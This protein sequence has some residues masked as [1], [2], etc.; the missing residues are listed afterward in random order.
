MTTKLV[1]KHLLKGTR[2][3]ELLDEQINVRM[4]TP[5]GQEEK[6]TVMLAVLNE[7]PVISRSEL[8]FTSRVNSE[9]LLSMFLAKPNQDEFN[10]FVNE[11]KERIKDEFRAFA[12]LK[13]SMPAGM[14]MNVEDEPPEFGSDDEVRTPRN[15]KTLRPEDLAAS[16]EQ[17]SAQLNPDDISGFLAALKE[18]QSDTNSDAHMARVVEEFQS[19]GPLQGAVLAYA[20]YVIAVLSDDPYENL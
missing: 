13:P 4:K 8:A 15:K 5:L 14:E 9:P 20:P 1:Q 19:L 11:V 17:L 18:L 16:I 7:E 10:A 6:L 3:F 2:E 12:G